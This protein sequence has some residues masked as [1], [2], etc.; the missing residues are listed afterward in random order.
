MGTGDQ[1][2]SRA[3]GDEIGKGL[4]GQKGRRKVTAS[5]VGSGCG[6]ETGGTDGGYQALVK[7][8]VLKCLKFNHKHLSN[9]VVH[10]DSIFLK[11]AKNQNK[12]KPR[13]AVWRKAPCQ[14]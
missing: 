8:L 1:T 4:L 5:E 12:T 7:G 13:S 14:L 6:R 10:G 2:R 3:W 9:F 11:N